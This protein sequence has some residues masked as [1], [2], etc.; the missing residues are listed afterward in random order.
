MIEIL[1]S[2]LSKAENDRRFNAWF[3]DRW[4]RKWL[5]TLNDPEGSDIHE[6]CS[7]TLTEANKF[8]REF[9]A[10]EV[11]KAVAE[12]LKQCEAKLSAMAERLAAA[13]G[14]LPQVRNWRP[15]TVAYKGQLFAFDG[16]VY[17]ARRDCASRPGSRDDWTLVAKSG[18]DGRDGASA[19]PRGEWTATDSYGPLDIVCRDG[20][21]YIAVRQNP[22]RPADDGGGWMMLAG[23]GSQGRTGKIG[24]MGPQGKT[25]ERGEQIH[26]WE[27]DPERYRAIP[28]LSTGEIGPSLELRP[29]FELFQQQTA[30]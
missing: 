28:V 30:E 2:R 12:V 5:A 8:T 21:S 1:R 18:V 20:C 6:L 22:G 17:Q 10:S 29:L 16:S 15:E 7:Y 11:S 4:D 27:L 26:H 3:D 14:E 24:P 13:S 9:V 23:K 19:T 25:G